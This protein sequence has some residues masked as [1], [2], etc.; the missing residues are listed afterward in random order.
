MILYQ[1]MHT[2]WVFPQHRS[3]HRGFPRLIGEVGREERAL[4]YGDYE[5]C[6]GHNPKEEVD[7]WVVTQGGI[8]TRVDLEQGESSG[9]NI[10]GKIRKVAQ[11][12]PKF[13]T[14]QQKKFLH[15]DKGPWKRIEHAKSCNVQCRGHWKK[16]EH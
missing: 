2:L 9:Q 7:V 8:H 6:E 13:N 16:P 15:D 5:P 10:E 4:Q 1:A 11:E 14:V 3:C 12:P